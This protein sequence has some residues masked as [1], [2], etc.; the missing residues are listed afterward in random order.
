MR[1]GT[2][3]ISSLTRTLDTLELIVRSGPVRTVTSIADELGQPVATVHRQVRTLVEAGFL[4]RLHNGRHA[5]GPRLAA[6]VRHV[7]EAELAVGVAAPVLADLACRLGSVMQLGTF[8]NDMVTYRV[9]AGRGSASLFTRVG[10]Q[11]EAYCSGIGKVLLA[12]LPSDARESY[13]A[14]GPFPALTPR[15]IVDPAQLR[16]ELVRVRERGYAIDD[17]EI[18]PGLRCIAVPVTHPDG[19]VLAAISASGRVRSGAARA[20]EETRA[21]LGEAAAAIVSAAF[22]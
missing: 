1:K 8:E 5:P 3:R 21:A 19:R 14:S 9:K 16:D 20:D 12:H 6:M 11:L 22:V 17:G 15:T 18:A 2:P 4:A 7:D 13:L 10:M